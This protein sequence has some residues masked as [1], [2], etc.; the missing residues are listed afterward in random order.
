M[1]VFHWMNPKVGE[2]QGQ[3][4]GVEREDRGCCYDN[5]TQITFVAALLPYRIAS[6]LLEKHFKFRD[7]YF[8][9]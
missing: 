5:H 7:I 8:L 4:S 2:L 1:M 9:I 3:R 6:L